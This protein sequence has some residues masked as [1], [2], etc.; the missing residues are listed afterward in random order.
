MPYPVAAVRNKNFGTP[1][2]VSNLVGLGSLLAYWPIGEA[3][4][5][6]CLDL[7]GNGYN[8]TYTAVTL[9]QAGNNSRTSGLWDGS[10]SYANVFSAGLAAAVNGA[11]G[12]LLL[13]GKVSAAG[14]WTDATTRSLFRL[15]VSD[16]TSLVDVQ[17]TTTDGTIRNRYTAGSTAKARN[18][19][20]LSTTGWFHLAMT[21]S[22]ANDRINNYLDGAAF[23]ATITG[24]GTW[25]GTITDVIIG[26]TA[27]TPSQVWSGYLQDVILFNRELTAAEVASVKSFFQ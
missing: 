15:N 9:A 12:S 19:A 22:K 7:S 16:V 6:A 4:G 2:F 11:E 18:V 23:G 1:T 3:S 26:A 5:T 17:R 24:L 8:G 14:V 20:P 25:G 27:L 21:W 10:T 13:W